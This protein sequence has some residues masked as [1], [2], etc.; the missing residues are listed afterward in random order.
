MR[1]EFKCKECNIS[2][3]VECDTESELELTKED[4]K[5]CSKCKEKK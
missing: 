5:Y 1:K 2:V 4:L 3:A